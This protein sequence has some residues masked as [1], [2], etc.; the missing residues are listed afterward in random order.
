MS[1]SFFSLPGGFSGFK[2]QYPLL[3]TTNN[4]NSAVFLS[5]LLNGKPSNSQ[6]IYTWPFKSKSQPHSP[7]CGHNSTPGKE[8]ALYNEFSNLFFSSS[9]DDVDA[10]PAEI[11]PYLY[12]GNESHASSK[13]LLQELGIT[14]VLNVSHNCT[15]YFEDQFA[16]KRISIRDS[17]S[18]DIYSQ[19]DEAI[20][21]ISKLAPPLSLSLSLEFKNSLE[22]V[23]NYRGIFRILV[24]LLPWEL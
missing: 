7:V 21:F 11:L 12:L 18:E 1:S 16:Y 13:S 14:A 2:K 6:Y 4:L 10:K 8:E 23:P 19:F 9:D 24:R 15:N 3:C 22:M 5:S 20:D 17:K